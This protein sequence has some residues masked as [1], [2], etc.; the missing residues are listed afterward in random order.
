MMVVLKNCE[1]L[2]NDLYITVG[3]TLVALSLFGYLFG[4][5]TEE[6]SNEMIDDVID[7]GLQTYNTELIDVGL[8]IN[9]L[10]LVDVSAKTILNDVVN[11]STMPGQWIDSSIGVQTDVTADMIA[12]VIN[13]LSV[14]E[15]VN[16]WQENTLKIGLESIVNQASILPSNGSTIMS[17]VALPIMPPEEAL[18]IRIINDAILHST[19]LSSIGLPIT[20]LD[21]V[22]SV[23]N[24]EYVSM[25]ND[26]MV[27]LSLG[28]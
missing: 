18:P 9:N 3:C 16:V 19:N 24:P 12:A 23:N 6:S 28:C 15:H 13:K 20:N 22:A 10:E 5:F 11:V 17:S 25:L 21:V 14:V 26:I 27:C 1:F 4:Y 2:G 8:Q 7:V